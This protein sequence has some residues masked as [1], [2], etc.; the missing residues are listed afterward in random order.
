MNEKFEDLRKENETQVKFYLGRISWA[1]DKIQDIL[2]EK[3]KGNLSID[4]DIQ[5]KIYNQVVQDSRKAL[6]FSRM[7]KVYI[8]ELE[9]EFAKNK[10][11]EQDE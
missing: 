10:T 4:L 7:I 11:G 1:W 2:G 6:E 9:K 8:D 3:E 5:Y